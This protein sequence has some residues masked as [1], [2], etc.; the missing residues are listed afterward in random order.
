MTDK[1]IQ[2]VALARLLSQCG[3]GGGE[4]PIDLPQS[5]TQGRTAFGG[6]SAALAYQ[7]ASQIEDDLPGL[8]SAQIAFVGPLFGRLT[9]ETEMLRRGKSTAFVGSN[10]FGDKGLGLHCSFVFAAQ[11]DTAVTTSDMIKPDFP[12]FPDGADLHS[13]PPQFFT[14]NM[15]YVGKRIDTSIKT[16]HLTRWMR[17]KQREDL[18][19]VAE[20]LCMG[21]SLPPSLM[22]LLDQNA[23][24]SSMNWQINIIADEIHT[25]DGWWL[26]DSHTHHADH[27][28]SS[29][30][31]SM[32][33]SEK[34]LIATGMQSVAY[35]A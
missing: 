9:A 3:K 10:I 4:N 13:G 28:A 20:L 32:W 8:R 11:R 24:V 16:N 7:A 26:I 17:L 25:A 2:P 31:M 27:G 29:Q 23:M 35:Y 1:K 21:D 5:W 30:Y 34:E 19:I 22:G 15:E 33:N 14:S 6:L 18:N 12:P